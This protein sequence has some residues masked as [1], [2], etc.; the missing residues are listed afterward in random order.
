MVTYN[1]NSLSSSIKQ[2]WFVANTSH[3]V[4]LVFHFI[5]PKNW[6]ISLMIR[7]I[8]TR[9]ALGLQALEFLK[10]RFLIILE[11]ASVRALRGV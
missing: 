7:W 2:M 10:V 8:G 5:G 9:Q 3:V 1:Q 6:V 4:D 11:L